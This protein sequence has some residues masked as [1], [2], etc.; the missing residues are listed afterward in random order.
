MN[1][2]NPVGYNQINSLSQGE[3]II[4]VSEGLPLFN[5][6]LIQVYIDF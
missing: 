2:R 5:G 6:T 1:I 3:S 4:S